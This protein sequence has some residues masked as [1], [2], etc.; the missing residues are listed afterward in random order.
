VDEES[1]HGLIK[2]TK[3]LGLI[4]MKRYFQLLRVYGQEVIEDAKKELIIAIAN[5]IMRSWM[6]S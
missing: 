5:V 3:K 4:T 6:N 2:K 1:N